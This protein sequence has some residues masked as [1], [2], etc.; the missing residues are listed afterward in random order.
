MANVVFYQKPGCRTNARQIAELR[1]AGHQVT[2]KDLV[3]EP[4]TAETL[5]PFFSGRPVASWFNPASPRLKSGEVRPEAFNAAAA[6]AMMVADPLLIRR[7]LLEVG[8]MRGVGF[9]GE[10]GASLALRPVSETC[11]RPEAPCPIPSGEAS[12]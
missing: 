10:P 2:V 5:L 1:E 8:G 11:S 9:D 12:P 7:P 6:L 4:W 3:R